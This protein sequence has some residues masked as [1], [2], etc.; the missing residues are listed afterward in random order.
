MVLTVHERIDQA[1]DDSTQRGTSAE[2]EGA[3]L[4]LA[5]GQR[6]MQNM[7]SRFRVGAIADLWVVCNWKGLDCFS[8]KLGLA[9]P[10]VLSKRP[11]VRRFSILASWQD[12]VRQCGNFGLQ[13]RPILCAG[14]TED[15]LSGYSVGFG[16]RS[17]CAS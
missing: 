14:L 3:Y 10:T 13:V 8:G 16:D 15:S 17:W 9:E 5:R 6:M 12:C 11:A 2:G 7:I 1:H 4:I